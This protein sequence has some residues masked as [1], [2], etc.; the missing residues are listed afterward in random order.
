MKKILA[1]LLFLLFLVL[2]WFSWRWYKD[3]VVCCDEDI[4]PA[5][6]QYGPLI[7]DCE[8]GD[9]IT[10]DLWPEKKQEI[11][12]E[13][14][15]NKSLLLAGPYF[16]SETAEDGVNRAEK[17]KLLFTEMPAEDIYTSAR[18]GGDCEATKETMLHELK[19]KWV[20]RNDDVIEH[21]DKTLVFYEYDSDKEIT[22]ENVLRFFDELSAFL[23]STGD[24]IMITGH[25]SNEG[26]DAYNEEL[27]MKRAIEFKNH[28]INLGVD[29]SQISV[30]SKGEA[31]PIES[32]DT[33]EGRRK[34]RRVE[35]HI[36]E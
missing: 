23:K 1:L 30:Q 31:M 25:T 21:L 34:N 32:N 3:T 12:N 28:L 13:R 16:G 33:E 14:T 22:N 7:F 24:K 8:T 19:Y 17:V 9:V 6:V 5:A 15:D 27:G 20:T 4:A 29:E 10:N 11:L 2:A 18:Y 36:T 26:E 35:I